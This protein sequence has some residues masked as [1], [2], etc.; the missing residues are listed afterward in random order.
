MLPTAI[1]SDHLIS[2]DLVFLDEFGKIVD[3]KEEFEPC[4]EM[5]CPTYEPI[6]PIRFIGN[7]SSG[8]MGIEIAKAFADQGAEVTLIL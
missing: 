6:D 5:I 2:L 7:H 4:G 1:L 8:R 3:I